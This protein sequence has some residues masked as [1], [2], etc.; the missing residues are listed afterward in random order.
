MQNFLIVLASLIIGI[1]LRSCRTLFLRKLGALSF[2][3]TSFLTLYLLS[4]NIYFGLIGGGL[5]FFLPWYDL[6]TRIRKQRIPLKTRLELQN[7]PSEDYFPNASRL[8]SEIEDAEFDHVVD[9][10]WD[11]AGMQQHFRF[12]WNPEM[13]SIAAICLCEQERVAFAFVTVSSRAP[14]GRSVHTTNYPFSPTLKHSPLAHW[15]HLPCERNHFEAIY[16]DHEKHLKKLEIS[17]DSLLTPDPDEVLRQVE[18][19]MQ[20]QIEHNLD[21]GLIEVIG[22]GHFRYS[23]KGLFFLWF[24]SVKDMIRLC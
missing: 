8:I 18:E 9:S 2:L 17:P 3:L 15:D 14:D 21:C 6:L 19:E 20:R 23:T 5:W 16:Q 10:G 22:D 4:G 1:A 11:W 13:K 12:F 24:Q 7:P